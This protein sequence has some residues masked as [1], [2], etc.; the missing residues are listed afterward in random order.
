[1]TVLV[2]SQIERAKALMYLVTETPVM[3][4]VA[5]EKIPRIIKESSRPF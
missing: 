3:L 1:M 5:I 2:T 4:N